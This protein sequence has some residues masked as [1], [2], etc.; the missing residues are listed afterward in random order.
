MINAP[1]TPDLPRPQA[2]PACLQRQTLD[3]HAAATRVPPMDDQDGL[4][5]A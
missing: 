4:H 3:G 5:R 1:S 2:P